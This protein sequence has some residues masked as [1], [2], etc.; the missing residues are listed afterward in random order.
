MRELSRA[1]RRDAEIAAV[2]SAYRAQIERMCA[3]LYSGYALAGN[4]C[5][6]AAE[7]FRKGLKLA[8]KAREAALAAVAES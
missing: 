1:A 4:E 2:E 7:R 6:A 8:R 5:D 3:V